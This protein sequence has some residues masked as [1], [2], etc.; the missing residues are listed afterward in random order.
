[1]ADATIMMPQTFDEHVSATLQGVLAEDGVAVS[2][3]HMHWL[4]RQYARILVRTLE[5][6]RREHELEKREHVQRRTRK[7]RGPAKHHGR[8]S[9]P[10]TT[11]GGDLAAGP[12]ASVEA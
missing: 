9:D 5:L 8:G 7:S 6:D 1:M 4:H 2:A 11:G 3:S 12:I 10:S